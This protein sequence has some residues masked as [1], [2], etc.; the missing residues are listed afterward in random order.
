MLL[1]VHPWKPIYWGRPV[2]EK[3]FVPVFF[4]VSIVWWRNLVF[5][6]IV[7]CS[8]CSC[9]SRSLCQYLPTHP[10]EKL[11][12]FCGCSG[13][14]NTWGN[15]LGSISLLASLT[16]THIPFFDN[17]RS[18]QQK[19]QRGV[20]IF[21]HSWNSWFSFGYFLRECSSLLCLYKKPITMQF[22]LFCC[23]TCLFEV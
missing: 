3:H 14:E 7:G 10:R 15:Y 1:S 18:I 9:I 6:N 4:S 23:T 12:L 17:M 8:R 16:R 19:R 21:Y 2:A 20:R 5:Q 11:K 22:W 13:A